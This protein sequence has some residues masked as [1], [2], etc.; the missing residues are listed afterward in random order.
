MDSSQAN[1]RAV[2]FDLDG[3]LYLQRPL[4]RRMLVELALSPLRGPRRAWRD[5]RRLRE[6]RRE[7]EALRMVGRGSESLEGL[8]YDD[9]TYPEVHRTPSA[10]KASMLGVGISVLPIMPVSP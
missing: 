6:F 3:T 2:V 10:A 8:Q 5:A 7:R 9:V 4:R 1:L